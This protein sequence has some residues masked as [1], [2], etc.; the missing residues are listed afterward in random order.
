MKY[1]ILWGFVCLLL[2]WQP[3]F[4]F[5]A[6]GMYIVIKYILSKDE[7]QEKSA[8]KK[9]QPKEDS[10]DPKVK[11]VYGEFVKDGV[12]DWTGYHKA[13]V[14]EKMKPGFKDDPEVQEL[15]KSIKKDMAQNR[16]QADKELQDDINAELDEKQ[17]DI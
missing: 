5:G 10:T 11:E 2:I 7:E 13:Q 14:K 4:V 15:Q 8:R 1:L 3:W 9:E 12:I 17:W 16:I 6:G